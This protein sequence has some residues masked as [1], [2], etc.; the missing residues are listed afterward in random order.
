MSDL[1]YHAT[2]RCCVH[3]LYTSGHQ[4]YVLSV[5]SLV[6]RGAA[7]VGSAPAVVATWLTGGLSPGFPTGGLSP[8]FPSP[9]FRPMVSCNGGGRLYWCGG[10]GMGQFGLQCGVTRLSWCR[11]AGLR[12]WE[13]RAVKIWLLVTIVGMAVVAIAGLF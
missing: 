5:A 4:K 8:G 1:A 9:G 10:V 7:V 11:G 3:Y 12:Q 2:Q 13:I 6:K